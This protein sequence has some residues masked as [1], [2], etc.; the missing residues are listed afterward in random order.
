MT[1]FMNAPL[2]LLQLEFLLGILNIALI[3]NI[4]ANRDNQINK[5]KI[6]KNIQKDHNVKII[7][8]VANVISVVKFETFFK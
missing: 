1:S 4:Q 6:F 5:L 3:N 7:N 2:D 8:L